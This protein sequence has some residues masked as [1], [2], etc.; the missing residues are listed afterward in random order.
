MTKRNLKRG[1]R[2]NVILFAALV[3]LL[4]SGCV[5]IAADQPEPLARIALVS[6]THTTRGTNEDQALYRGRLDKVIAAVNSSRPDAVLIAGDLTQDGRPEEL[7]DF[8]KQIGGFRAPVLFVPG[9]HDVGNKR[10]GSKAEGVTI[11]RV[12]KF[13]NQMGPSFFAKSL[14][15][16][17]VIGLNSPIFGSGF[18]REEEMWDLLEKELAQPAT[19]ATIL[20]MHYPPFVKKADEAGGDYW[21]IEPEPRQRLLGLLRKGGVKTVLTGHLHRQLINRLDGILFVTTPPVSFGLPK[22]KQPEGWTLITLPR[23]GEA[24]VQFQT[25]PD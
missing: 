19:Q 20:F 7:S 15:G 6:D 8:Q 1:R 17:R 18:R 10:I 4:V 11:E 23:Q 12:A 24:Q 22:G 13:E 21:N 16:V 14:S 25:I 3:W 5:L 2:E 9:N